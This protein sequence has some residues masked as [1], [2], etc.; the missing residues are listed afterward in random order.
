MDR[1]SL[2]YNWMALKYMTFIKL[3]SGVVCLAIAALSLVMIGLISLA[4]MAQY[5]SHAAGASIKATSIMIGQWT[6]SGWQIYAV[7]SLLLVLSVAFLAC[8]IC[9]FQCVNSAD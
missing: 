6:L 5:S 4:W 9:V 2:N 1:C 7:A 3:I 8:G